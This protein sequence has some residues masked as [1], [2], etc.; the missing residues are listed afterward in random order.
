MIF[1]NFSRPD[2][3]IEGEQNTILTA[4][5]SLFDISSAMRSVR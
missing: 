5:L 4:A 1:L 2:T 3:Q